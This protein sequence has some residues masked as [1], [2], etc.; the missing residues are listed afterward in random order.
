MSNPLVD[1][2]LSSF[3]EL[4]RSISVTKDN[5]SVKPGV[6]A[7]VLERLN[8]YSDIVS[9]QRDLAQELRGHIEA[10]RWEEVARAVK[11]I[12][13]LSSMIRDDAQ[14]ILMSAV[15]G[16]AGLTPATKDDRLLC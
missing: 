2:L 1:K 3:D 9:K 15:Q 6:P 14:Q 8:Q 16:A 11:V 12:N 4:E 10:A 5:L 13:G 7:D